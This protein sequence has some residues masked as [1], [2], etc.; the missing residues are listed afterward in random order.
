MICDT[1]GFQ[2]AVCL[3]V[4]TL[5]LWRKQKK[6][7]QICTDKSKS[8]GSH[9]FFPFHLPG[10]LHILLSSQT[11]TILSLQYGQEMNHSSFSC[12]FLKFFILFL[13]PPL[14][15]ASPLPCFPTLDYCQQAIGMEVHTLTLDLLPGRC[16]SSLEIIWY[17]PIHNCTGHTSHR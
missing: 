15:P 13:P 16:L 2:S 12:S 7:R 5:Y 4:V 14:H 9:F 3:L 11:E 8:E 17:A 10:P 1:S 6:K